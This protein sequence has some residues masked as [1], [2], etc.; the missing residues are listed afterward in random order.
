MGVMKER[1][2]S[3]SLLGANAPFIEELYETWLAHP[4]SV[5]AEW[6]G[7]FAELRGDSPDVP[8]APVV[9]SFVELGR[10]GRVRGAMVDATTMAKQVLVLRLISKYRTLGFFHAELDPLRRHEPP[11]LADLDFRTYGFTDADLDTEFDVGSFRAGPARMRLRDIHA[12][13]TETYTRTLGLEYMYISDTATRRFL[14]ERVEPTRARPSF[15]PGER[16]HILERLTAAETLERYLH[17]KYV[18]QKRFSGEGGDTMIPML[19]HLIQRAGAAGIQ[20]IVMGMAH[21]GRLNVL[22]NTLGKMPADLFSEFEGKAAQELPAG[23]VKYHQ[24]FSSDIA[25]PGG[26]AHVTLAFNPSHLEIV[27][28]VV[29]GSVRARQHR[30]GDRMGD[31]VLPVVIHGDAAI[32]GQGVNQECLNMAQT[33][34]FYTGGTVHIVVNNQIGFTTSD[35]RDT[36]GTLYCTDVAKMVDAPV[37]HVNGDDPET[38]L[39]AIDI[40][41][42]Y[43][44]KFHKDV[45]IDLVC[46]RRY[47]HNEAD[48][49]M[50]TQPLMYKKIQAHPGTRRLYADRLEQAGVIA[51]GDADAQVAAYRAAMDRGQHTNKTVLSNYKPPFTVD[52][53]PY[54]GRHWT[55]PC[56]TRVPKKRLEEIAATMTTVPDHFKLH[57]R[58]ERVIADRKAMGE[59]RLPLD[60]GMGETLAY[61]SLLDQGFGV[62]LSGE[63][64]ARGTFSHRHAVLHDQ[65]REKWDSGSY[66]PLEHV[67]PGQPSIE[68]IDS[69][70]TENATMAFEYGYAT[71]DPTRLVIWEAQFGD[72]ANGA[73]VVIDQFISAGEVKWGRICGLVL[74]LPHGYEGQGP[75]H[76]SARPE[77]FLQLCAQHNMQVVV[78]TTPAQ[79]FHMLRRQMIRPYRKPLVVMSPKSLLRHKEAVSSMDDLAGGHFHTVIGEVEPIDAKKVRRVV[80][81][82]GK[83]YYDLAAFRREKKIDDIAILRV[84]QQYPFPHADFKAEI[85]R[86]AKA[87][88]VVWCQEEPQNQGAWYRLRAYLRADILDS[89]VLA[90]AGRSIS[91]SPAVGYAAKHNA[92]QKQLI[93]DAFAAKLASGEMVV[94]H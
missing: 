32:A 50:V 16:R 86:Y 24:G 55:D 45:F 60:W 34:G 11:Y 68:V 58:V 51:P 57:S 76:S 72:F 71:S 17:T 36:R 15:T 43:R 65:N 12:A 46:F 81:C 74:L 5:P 48:E 35:P 93:E 29:E 79:V 53:A 63:D 73:Q 62:R 52:W 61:A 25:T 70:L 30:R 44:Q 4:E 38:C 13:L 3:S 26:P 49:P 21:R 54:K 90:Y 33:R 88:E 41:L 87:K 27:N 31:Q 94:A 9:Q 39:L 47:G 6:A 89:Q 64:V 66:M 42:E 28:P 75:E 91:A 59:G 8:H 92:E 23:D 84:E 78:P 85:A 83:V 19:D 40:A 20:E 67:K 56:D 18:G 2:G 37:L 1:E 77:R 10:S 7:Y 22:V 14:Q 69:V 82:S 80:V